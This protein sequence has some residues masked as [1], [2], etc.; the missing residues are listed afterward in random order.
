MGQNRT[1]FHL[2]GMHMELAEI[3]LLSRDVFTERRS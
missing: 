1:R 3:D 2:G